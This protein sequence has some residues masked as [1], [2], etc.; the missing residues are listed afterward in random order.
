[1][2]DPEASEVKTQE[3]TVGDRVNV[4]AD[5]PAHGGE[6]IGTVDERVVFLEG[7]LP[8]DTVVATVTQKKKRFLR[9]T[10]DSVTELSLIHI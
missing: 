1:M 5:R 2:S 8:G 10:V 4:R 9:A 3:I 7:A 6:S